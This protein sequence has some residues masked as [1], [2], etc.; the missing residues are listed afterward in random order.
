[1]WV[2]VSKNMQ[3]KKQFQ[4][5]TQIRW[6]TCL[7]W[8]FSGKMDLWQDLTHL[9]CSCLMAEIRHKKALLAHLTSTK[10]SDLVH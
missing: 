3:N 2:L 4:N 5:C 9:S 7:I 8:S 10:I 6:E 1:M